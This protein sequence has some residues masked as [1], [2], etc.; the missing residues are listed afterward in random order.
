MNNQKK[1]QLTLL[2]TIFLIQI[3]AA[4]AW[5]ETPNKY[6]KIYS[7]CLSEAEYTNNTVVIMCS[8]NTTKVVK[9]EMNRLYD[10][11]YKMMAERS[12]E[13]AQKLEDSQKSLAQI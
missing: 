4:I 1:H 3:V 9:R 10:M 2:T 12:Q 6:E 5:A 8:E 13:D 11:T 7:D